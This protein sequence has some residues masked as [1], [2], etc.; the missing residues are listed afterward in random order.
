MLELAEHQVEDFAIGHAALRKSNRT[1]IS[2]DASRS[3]EL[4]D[5]RGQLG[6]G[7]AVIRWLAE[8]VQGLRLALAWDSLSRAFGALTCGIASIGAGDVPGDGYA[9]ILGTLSPVLLA[10][11]VVEGRGRS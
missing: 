9:P 8:P 4:P 5:V 7:Q 2:Q 10:V 6:R 3:G 1:R 11:D